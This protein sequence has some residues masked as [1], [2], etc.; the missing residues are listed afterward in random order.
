MTFPWPEPG[1]TLDQIKDL[2][3]ALIHGPQKLRYCMELICSELFMLTSPANH[4]PLLQDLAKVMQ[5]FGMDATN[6]EQLVDRDIKALGE[7]LTVTQAN[8]ERRSVLLVPAFTNRSNDYWHAGQSSVLASGTA[9]VFC[10]AVSKGLSV[11]GSCF[12]GFDSAQ[13]LVKD[14]PGLVR[15]LTPY[16]GWHHGILQPS[17]LGALNETDQALVVVDLD[18]VHVVSGKPRPQL[19]PEP[20]SM[21]AYLPIVEVVRKEDNARALVAALENQF[22][23]EK[24][25]EAW[26]DA[27]KAEA[28]PA[29][30]EAPHTW[31][32][33]R[34]AFERLL[35]AR[36]AGRLLP[37]LGGAELDAFAGFFSDPKAVRERILANL[38][39][40]HQQPAP[41]SWADG[42]QLE[43]AWLD[44]L[45]ADLTW[46]T[47]EKPPEIRVP[48]WR[49]S[50]GDATPF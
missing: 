44:F 25:R 50:G 48:P 14:H 30:C 21:V 22:K 29:P 16:H 1:Q 3:H 18:P 7:L 42:R 10:N 45:V 6:A 15:L 9:T 47:S 20:M 33:F 39:D 19:L 11:G 38:M 28:L 4:R 17:G 43:P 34:N 13:K 27:F 24:G 35:E 5:Q 46:K 26:Q 49:I 41:L 12:I 23:D 40:R 36:E 37:E 8:R 32:H 2:M 31:E